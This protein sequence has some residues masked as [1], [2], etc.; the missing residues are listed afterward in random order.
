[1]YVYFYKNL[2]TLLNRLVQN[3]IYKIE[4][5]KRGVFQLFLFLT[6]GFCMR[7]HTT[8]LDLRK[9]INDFTAHWHVAHVA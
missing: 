8:D 1:M 5:F 9:Y 4:Q 3:A 7:P 2:S 6:D